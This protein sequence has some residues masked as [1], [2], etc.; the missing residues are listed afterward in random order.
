[1]YIHVPDMKRIVA[2]LGVLGIVVAVGGCESLDGRNRIRKG[3]RLFKDSCFVAAAAEYEKSMTEIDDPI[4]HYN[5]G[6]ALQKVLKP[7]ADKPILLDKGSSLM[8]DVTKGTTSV[9]LRACVAKVEEHKTDEKCADQRFVPCDDKNI[10]PSSQTCEKVAV[11]QI[12]PDVLADMV[13]SN[14]DTWLKTHADD[15]ETR[16]LMTQ[17]WL[18]TNQ[19]KKAIDYWAGLLAQKP[20]DPSIMGALAGIELKAGNWRKSI[21]WYLKV[22]DAT[23]DTAA[24]VNAL[25]F[26]G[27]VGWA[28]LNSKTLSQA[29][30]I[31]LA[32]RAIGALQ[33]AAALSPQNPK[34][35]GLQASIFNFRAM[36]QSASW[37]AAV[38]RAT[39][40]DL[41]HRSRVLS[42]E[43]KKAQGLAPTS[44]GSGGSTAE[45]PPKTGG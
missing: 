7:G 1:M 4:I 23:N 21:E 45:A 25:Q 27:N 17:V 44:T 20:N 36:T 6:L 9:D 42:D 33:K 12:A 43:A 11:C 22:A 32:D 18:D 35:V 19:Y 3:N 24:K 10:C 14:F 2:I 15:A 40:Q 16:A 30:S 13:T 37:A 34:Y 28:K 41:Q 38:D 31:E 39:A 26:I 8:C 29:E 5:L